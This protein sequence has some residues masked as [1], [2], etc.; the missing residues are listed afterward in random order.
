MMEIDARLFTL[1]AEGFALITLVL[2]ASLFLGARRRR[3]DRKALRALVASINA[4]AGARQEQTRALFADEDHAV[5]L[6]KQ[7]RA[8]CQAFIGAYGK[9]APEALAGVYAQ[10]KTLVD[11]YQQRMQ[12]VETDVGDA[13]QDEVLTKLKADYEQVT[14]ELD[15]TKRTMEKMMHEYNS[16]FGGGAEAAQEAGESAGAEAG[17]SAEAGDG[18]SE[19]AEILRQLEAADDAEVSPVESAPQAADA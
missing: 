12:Q 8:V 13:A 7:E 15:I 19:A 1:L 9:R 3:K 5:S 17:E 10:L 16:M 11:G 14:R 18:D 6:S 4:E 2:L